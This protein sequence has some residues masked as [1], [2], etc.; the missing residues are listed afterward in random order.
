MYCNQSHPSGSCTT[1]T[2]I[3]AWKE[4]LRKAGR[5][6][7]CLRKHHLGRCCRS[8]L[9]C[10]KCRGRHHVTICTRHG[11][12][13][14]TSTPTPQGSVPESLSDSP[15]DRSTT[16]RPTNTLYVG[17]QTPILL[18]TARLQVFNPRSGR[19]GAMTRAI[20]DSGSQ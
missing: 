12:G 18:Q 8:T 9:N 10:K 5:C 1:V 19:P 3:A 4:I 13:E 16:E 17:A 11:L 14:A 7:T 6:Y 2:D 15:S 20:M